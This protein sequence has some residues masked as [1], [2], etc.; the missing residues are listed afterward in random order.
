MKKMFYLN[1]QVVTFI[2]GKLV[3]SKEIISS[4]DIFIDGKTA[5]DVGELV[6]KDREILSENG[7]VIVSVTLNKATKQIVAGP[8][9]YTR[10]FVFV[11]E[12]IDLIKEAEKKALEIINENTK[13]NFIDFNKVRL[14]IRDTL[15]KYFYDE[16]E[17]KPMILLVIGEVE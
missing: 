2:D 6:I 9:I 11:K 12:N 8:E 4:D 14:G 10:G 16:T 13:P 1:G 5:G 17:C 15:G 7:V 3:E